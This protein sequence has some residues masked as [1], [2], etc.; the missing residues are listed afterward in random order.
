MGCRES[1]H[2]IIVEKR[3]FSMKRNDNFIL[4]SL[5]EIKIFLTYI[6]DY[7]D[8]P[9]DYTTLSRIIMDNVENPSLD[10]E[11]ALNALSDD[12]YLYFD[13]VDG[14]KYYMITE[15]GRSLASELYDTL[16]ENIREKSIRVAVKHL[17][18]AES[19]RGT[20]TK[21]EEA[22]NNRFKVTVE[23]HSRIGKIMR[24]SM[25]VPSRGEAEQ[26]AERYENRPD[27]VYRGVMFALTG[28]LELID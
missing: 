14:E 2:P 27:A 25:L 4:S 22:D 24:V 19:G 3:N 26:I 6:L 16:D 20:K 5:T 18:F 9:L 23:A 7:V 21:I 12:G 8:R 15:I 13:E 10:Y 11:E 28:R 1:R 17:S